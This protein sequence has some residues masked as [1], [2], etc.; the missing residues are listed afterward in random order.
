MGHT[1]NFKASFEAAVIT[2]KTDRSTSTQSTERLLIDAY[3]AVSELRLEL[4]DGK[5]ELGAKSGFA[6]GDNDPS[7][8]SLNDFSFDRNFGVGMVIFDRV[9]ADVDAQSVTLLSDPASVG[10][11]PDG[12]DVLV[13]EG[14][15]RRA[16]FVQPIVGLNP[17]PWFEMKA[18]LVLAWSTAPVAH[19]FYTVRAGGTPMNQLGRKTNGYD[20]GQEINWAL[21]VTPLH[22]QSRFSSTRISIQ[23]GH[24]H[25]AANIGDPDSPPINRFLAVLQ[26]Q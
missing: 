17:S 3:G 15:L 26:V 10:T 19:P 13:H 16:A 7:D 12:V 22:R 14:S 18:G 24:A 25:L 20:L 4:A 9:M 21:T 2:G 8:D 11:P 5:L 6:S 1:G 23:G